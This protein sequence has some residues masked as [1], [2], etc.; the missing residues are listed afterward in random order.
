[1]TDQTKL[2][3]ILKDELIKTKTDTMI[4]NARAALAFDILEAMYHLL[5]AAGILPFPLEKAY[6]SFQESAEEERDY[7]ALFAISFLEGNRFGNEPPIEDAKRERQ[8]DE[9]RKIIE[10]KIRETIH[11]RLLSLI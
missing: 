10:N 8:R 11:D 6:Q 4:A 5:D 3:E 7:A 1:M 2:I 9:F